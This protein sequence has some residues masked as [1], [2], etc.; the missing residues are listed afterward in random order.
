VF[1]LAYG[2]EILNDMG[3]KS[4]VVRAGQANMFLSD[5]FS[6]AFVNTTGTQVELFN[7]DGAQGAARAAGVGSGTYSSMASA[8]DGLTCLRQIEPDR[9]KQDAYSEAY[10][11]WKNILHQQLTNLS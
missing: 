11:N 2:F 1:S 9:R 5:V 3:L 10:D 7:T 4:T 6:E 8:F